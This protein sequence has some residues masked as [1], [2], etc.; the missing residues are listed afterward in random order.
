MQNLQ[1]QEMDAQIHTLIKSLTIKDL[2][3]QLRARGESP[4]GGQVRVI[5]S[6]CMAVSLM[7]LIYIL[8]RHWSTGSHSLW[9]RLVTSASRA[10]MV[11]AEIKRQ[12][13][14]FLS[15]F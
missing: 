8:R 5:L 10:K 1:A 7:Y 11:R 13:A 2:R 6:F 14:D 15:K 4:A 9:L 12:L 3:I